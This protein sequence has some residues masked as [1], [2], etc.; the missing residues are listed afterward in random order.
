MGTPSPNSE[1]RPP[2]S[3]ALAAG[4][5]RKVRPTRLITRARIAGS[6]Q[7]WIRIWLQIEFVLENSP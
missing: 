3:A 5:E 6:T 1:A 7:F 4:T 2:S